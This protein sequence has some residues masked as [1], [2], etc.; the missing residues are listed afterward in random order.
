MPPFSFLTA[1]IIS[2]SSKA[3]AESYAINL[4]KA[5]ISD[6][7]I[8]VFGPVEAPLFLLRG[9]YRFRLLLKAKS[10]NI[11]NDFTRN[12]LKNCPTPANVRLIIDVDPYT[13]V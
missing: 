6:D 2:G 5:H 12:L 7:N 10:R 3:R 9:Q 1:I 13:F 8:S 11:L 4:T